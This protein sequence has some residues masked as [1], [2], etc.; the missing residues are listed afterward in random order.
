MRK[1]YNEIAMKKGQ[2]FH[3]RYSERAGIM[4]FDAGFPSWEAE[5]LA[6]NETEKIGQLNE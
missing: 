1:N 2:D 5:R 6:Y 3:D 4:Q